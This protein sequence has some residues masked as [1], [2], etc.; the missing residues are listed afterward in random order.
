MR[1]PDHPRDLNDS[2]CPVCA[3]ELMAPGDLEARVPGS[4]A[5]LAPAPTARVKARQCPQC[6]TPMVPQRIERAE[7]FVER[8]PGCEALWVERSDLRT[9]QLYAKSAARRAA[10]AS[11]SD[12]EK[13][14]LAHGLAEATKGDTGPDVGVAQAALSAATGVPLVDKLQGDQTPY[15]TW[16][17]AAVLVATYFTLSA[18]ALAYTSGSGDVLGALT[19][20]FAHFGR[21][22]LAGNVA[23]LLVFGTAVERRLPRLAFIAALVL[24]APFTAFS[25]ALDAADGTLIGGASGV[26]AGLLGL[27]LFVQPK[28]RV[29]MF[30]RFDR[31]YVPLWVYGLFWAGM[32]WLLWVT[33]VPGI[34]WL[35]HLGGFAAGLA[36]GFVFSR[37]RPA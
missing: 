23:F 8:C 36:A 21:W 4:S 13:K 14:E 28:A 2:K 5:L 29:T 34:G 35:A 17:Y 15:L 18:E 27:C 10:Y 20:G 25:Q 1:C 11:M 26:V 16:L 9:L 24:L 22:H 3:G 19:S 32:Q 7:A 12:A 37:R 31:I 30:I 6:S 33:G